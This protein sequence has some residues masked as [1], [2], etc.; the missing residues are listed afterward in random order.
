MNRIT[1]AILIGTVSLASL[2]APADAQ[3]A[4]ACKSL[5]PAAMGGPMPGDK[6]TIVLRWLSTSNYEL[7]FRDQVILLDAYFEQGPR[8]RPTGIVPN[9]VKKTDAIFVG[10]P[11][12]DHISDVGPISQ[13]TSARVIGAPITIDTAYK[14]GIPQG[15]GTSVADGETL[16]FDGFN[17]DAALAQHSTLKSEVLQTLGK[18]YDADAGPATPEQAAAEAAIRAKG[19]FDP[20]VIT[21]GTIAYGFTFDTGFKLV[22]L[23]SA[24]P[25]TDRRAGVSTEA[26]AGAYRYQHS[27]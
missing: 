4:D 19:T 15:R 1:A 12:F 2:V 11:H 13:R 23:D 18:L 21:K 26:R 16:K 6:N 8:S 20:D 14:L 10:H 7:A 22:W 24:G 5:V 3:P 27:L 9:E 25:V 17:V